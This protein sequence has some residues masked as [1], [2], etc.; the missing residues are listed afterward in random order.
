[1]KIYVDHFSMEL[2]TNRI[3]TFTAKYP[4]KRWSPNEISAVRE[5]FASHFKNKSL[6]S[7]NKIKEKRKIIVALQGRKWEQ[8]KTYISNANKKH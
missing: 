4:K 8:I 7:T 2:L 1:M 6:P 3:S 5:A